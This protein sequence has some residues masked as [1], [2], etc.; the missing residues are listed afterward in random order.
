MTKKA[1][2]KIKAGLDD[3]IDF[4]KGKADRDRYG[5]HVPHRDRMRTRGRG[6]GTTRRVGVHE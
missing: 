6:A 3:A 5:I 4:A 1:F 2:E